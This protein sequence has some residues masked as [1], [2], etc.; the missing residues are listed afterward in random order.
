MHLLSPLVWLVE[1]LINVSDT[2]KK[3]IFSTE[4]YIFEFDP[5]SLLEAW[6]TKVKPHEEEH[7]R[8]GGRRGGIN[9]ARKEDNFFILFHF[10]NFLFL[11]LLAIFF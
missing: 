1:I 3:M 2:L 4:N 9:D 7:A 6:S 8:S 11:E 5:S 10:S